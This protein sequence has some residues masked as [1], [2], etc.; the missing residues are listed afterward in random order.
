MTI[1]ISGPGVGLP[2]PSNL[3]PSELYSAP[4]DIG[5][6]Y[7]DLPPGFAIYNLPGDQLMA[8][9]NR[10]VKQWLDPITGTWRGYDAAR[11]PLQSVYSDGFTQRVANL[12]GC[13]IGAVV[14]GG[15]TLFVQSSATITPNLGGSLWQ[16][17][18]GGSL[19]VSTIA[20]AGTNFSIRPIVVIPDPPGVAVN[21]VGGVPATAYATLT[22]NT[23]S[24]VTLDNV[25]AGYVAATVTA[26]ILPSPFDPNLGSI[27]AGTVNFVLTNSGLITA[28]LCTNNG[29]PLATLSALTLT[30]AGGAGSGATLQPV[31]MQCATAIAVTGGGVGW[32]DATHPALITSIG[33]QPSSVSAITNPSVEHTGYRPRQLVASGTCNA[34]GTITAVTLQDPGLFAGTPT[35]AVVP[36]N[37]GI[38]TTAA[39]L[40][41]TMG[42]TVDSVQIQPR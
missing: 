33:G 9:G 2:A 15:G 18:V 4:Y 22:N 35:L 3:Y 16:A 34:G 24:A 6:A 25:G 42:S 38:A 19:T 11:A 14:S 40:A 28:A 21:G 7:V 5:T 29:A 12:T 1:R 37:G 17:V 36:G 27:T 20:N 26:L 13:P 32:G 39:T 31:M 30:A 10:S 23:V 41:L 8:M